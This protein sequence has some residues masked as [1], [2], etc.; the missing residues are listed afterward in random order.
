MT[1]EFTEGSKIPGEDPDKTFEAAKR[2]LEFLRE[3]WA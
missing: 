1:L 2:D 3:H